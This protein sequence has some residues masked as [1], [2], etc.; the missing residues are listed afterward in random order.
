MVKSKLGSSCT[1][2]NKTFS[3][4]QKRFHCNFEQNS[5]QISFMPTLCNP[6]LLHSPFQVPQ[7]PLLGMFAAQVH[8]TVFQEPPITRVG[9]LPVGKPP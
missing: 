7:E 5:G 1:P 4:L 6:S 3:N 2:I 8:K 9:G